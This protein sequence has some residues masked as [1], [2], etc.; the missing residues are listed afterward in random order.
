MRKKRIWKHI[1]VI[2]LAVAAATAAIGG[3][4]A[5]FTDTQEKTNTL[6]VGSVKTDLEEPEWEDVPSDEKTDITPN[7]TIKKDPR[8]TNTGANDAYAFLEIQVPV[9]KIITVGP[10]G[11]KLPAADTE[12]FTYKVN[13]GWVQV[14][15]SDITTSGKVTARSYAE[16][17]GEKLRNSGGTHWRVQSTF[18][19]IPDL[20]ETEPVS[21]RGDYNEKKKTN[22]LWPGS[23]G[24]GADRNSGT[25]DSYAGSVSL[26]RGPQ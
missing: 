21:R 16:Y 9:K 26:F 3:I 8:I 13:D 7:Q 20:H 10:D 18:R 24:F 17:S 19:R 6:T 14:R 15:S 4:S 22:S 11:K 5:Y 25:V 23:G 12:L 2:A 1:T